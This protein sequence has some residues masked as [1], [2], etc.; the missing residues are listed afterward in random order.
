M[1]RDRERVD[2]KV[3]PIERFAHENGWDTQRTYGVF[4]DAEGVQLVGT[5]VDGHPEAAHPVTF[6]FTVAFAVNPETGR[7]SALRLD[8]KAA[9]AFVVTVDDETGRY[10]YGPLSAHKRALVD[11]AEWTGVELP[12]PVASR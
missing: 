8:G 3:D 5:R 12:Q 2:R 7:V 6:G 9:A 4:G 11:P 10:W 1:S